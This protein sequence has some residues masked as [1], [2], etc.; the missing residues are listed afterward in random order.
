[1]PA[2]R[3]VVAVAV[4]V[5]ALVVLAYGVFLAVESFIETSPSL[6][7][8][9]VLS[10]VTLLIGAGL[11]LVARAV[12]AG[13]RGARAPVLV[14][15][16]LQLVVALPAAYGRPEAL[17]PRWAGIPLLALCLVA[18]LGVLRRDAVDDPNDDLA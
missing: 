9:L 14:W 16:L 4:L 5:E 2:V 1:M 11:L 15:Q 6:I 7:G 8:S 18:G 12:A 10:L 13:R 3:R 17:M